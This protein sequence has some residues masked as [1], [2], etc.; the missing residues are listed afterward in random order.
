VAQGR[1][2]LV[3]HPR[4]PVDAALASSGPLTADHPDEPLAGARQDPEVLRV[5]DAL[6]R[7]AMPEHEVAGRSGMSLAEVADAL[8][9]AQLQ[10]LVVH[11]S[12]GWARA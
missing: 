3:V 4:D 12:G 8:A 2:Q 10:G 9:L 11:G 5:L 7:R 6:G 1:A